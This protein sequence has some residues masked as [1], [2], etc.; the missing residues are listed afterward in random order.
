MW[1]NRFMKTEKKYRIIIWEIKSICILLVSFFLHSLT[2]AHLISMTASR[3][4]YFLDKTF[5][6]YH[7]TVGV[8]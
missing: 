6:L 2:L 8:M 7:T 5:L 4:K 3:D 1:Y